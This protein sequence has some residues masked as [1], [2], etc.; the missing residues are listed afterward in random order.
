M[1]SYKNILI[2]FGIFLLTPNI[3][4]SAQKTLSLNGKWTLI[5]V[6]TNEEYVAQVPGTFH[7][8]L[9]ANDVIDEPYFELNEQK[10][11]YL[12]NKNWEYRRTF[13]ISDKHLNS[14]EVFLVCEGIDTYSSITINNHTIGHT[15][16]MFHP[17]EFNIRPYL[18]KGPNSISIN[19]TSPFS[20]HKDKVENWPYVFPAD[21]EKG[22]KKYSP[23]CRKA[24]YHFGWDWGPRFVTSGIYKNIHLRFQ[25]DIF[26]RSSHIQTIAINQDKATLL[27]S[28]ILES[29]ATFD[30]NLSIS[31]IYN[32]NLRVKEG[33]TCVRDTIFL[34]NPQLWWPNGH[35]N[36]HLYQ[37][38]LFVKGNDIRINHPIKFGVRTI[39]LINEEDDVGT[40]FYFIVNG[41][42][43]FAKG[44]NYIPQDL[45]LPRVSDD[46]YRN[47]LQQVKDANMNMI[48]V[49]G[50]GIYEKDIFYNLCDSLGLMVWQDFMF[51]GTMYPIDSAFISSIE[52]EVKYQI[53]RL[54]AHPC[55][56]IWCGNNEIEVAWN[57]WGWQEK[58]Q[59]SEEVQKELWSGYS[60]LFKHQIPQ[61]ITESDSQTD[62]TTTSPLSNW[63]KKENFN[64]S[65]MHYWGVWHGREDFEAFE[66]N[67]GRFMV[68]Y[69]MQSYPSCTTLQ[70]FVSPTEL[71]L[72][73][74]T[75]IHR[76]KSYIGNGE[77]IKKMIK[78]GEK[79]ETFCDF[80]QESQKV[81]GLALNK[82]IEAHLK[83]QPHCMGSLLW[84][85]NDCWPGPSW[86][87]IDYYGHPKTSYYSVK[88]AFNEK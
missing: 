59:Y 54:Q 82:A 47:L 55:L 33:T 37:D 27:V 51:A 15:T 61:W 75:M 3:P 62:Y 9:L 8:D 76:Q 17:W 36:S 77:I 84:Q 70:S 66:R 12:E 73:S 78:Y 26:I 86:S 64:H 5:D 30:L 63:G 29:N 40:S 21:S 6:Q 41:K 34:D 31:N 39:E 35:G 16:N 69:G 67:V 11:Q 19:L 23:F 57:N 50:G 48:R 25:E 28:T 24:L 20:Y 43:V 32:K 56:A 38:T 87:I 4:I 81:Q 42:P 72:H 74:E 45:F 14:R 22:S 7:T 88:K 18:K 65:S 49:W 13:Q 79:P 83:K 44:A 53:N 2:I 58:Y 85:L 80:V 1:M 68:E 10:Y 46:Q 71:H 52:T 60:Q